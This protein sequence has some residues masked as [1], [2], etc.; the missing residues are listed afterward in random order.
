ML[1]TR[2]GVVLRPDGKVGLLKVEYRPWAAEC[3]IEYA[4]KPEQNGSDMAKSLTFTGLSQPPR[5]RLNGRPVEVASSSSGGAAASFQ[6]AL[7][8]A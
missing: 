7:A 5:V 8:P 4:P 3:D 1:T 2:D 6:I